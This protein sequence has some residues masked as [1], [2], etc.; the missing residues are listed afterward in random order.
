RLDL[1]RVAVRAGFGSAQHLR[2]VWARWE[3]QPP[4]ALRRGPGDLQ[5]ALPDAQP[6]KTTLFA[7]GNP[8]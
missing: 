5:V 8:G 2:R 6:A 3:A 1:E 4:S 7:G